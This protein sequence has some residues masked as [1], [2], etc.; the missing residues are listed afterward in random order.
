[1][2]RLLFVF[3]CMAVFSTAVWSQGQGQRQQRTPEQ[4]AQQTTDWMKTECK[5]TDKQVAPVNEI[6]LT[7]AKAAQ[8]LRENMTGGDFAAMREPMQKLEDQRVKDFEKILTKDQVAT[9]KKAAAERMQRRP[10]GGGGA[11][12]GGGNRPNRTN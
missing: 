4:S 11:G 3:I 10:G 6:N 2:K 7:Y 5:L 8:K 1:M 12:G 9:Y